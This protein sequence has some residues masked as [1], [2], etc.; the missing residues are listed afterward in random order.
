MKPYY[1]LQGTIGPGSTTIFTVSPNSGCNV[2][3]I[4]VHNPAAYDFTLTKYQASTAS[5]IIVYSLSLSAGDTV[6]DTFPYVF[7][8]GD[9][10]IFTSSIAGTTYQ[11]L[12]TES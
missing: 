5:T 11:V 12:V 6:T 1:P 2:G 4:R 7:E 9:Q 3:N 8:P 10:L